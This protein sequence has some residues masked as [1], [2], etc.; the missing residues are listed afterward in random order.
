MGEVGG[1]KTALCKS[2]R[3]AR[4]GRVP[5]LLGRRRAARR[6]PRIDRA[7]HSGG[8]ADQGDDAR[9]TVFDFDGG[10]YLIGGGTRAHNN[11]LILLHGSLKFDSFRGFE[12]SEALNLTCR[13]GDT[14]RQLSMTRGENDI[15][16]K[17]RRR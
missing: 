14:A 3:R 9:P 12:L 5:D 7:L 1:F 13:G 15:P 17:S 6:P 2:S 16:E 8:V 11:Q 10:E 4:T